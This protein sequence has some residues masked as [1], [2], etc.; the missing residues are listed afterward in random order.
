MS[1]MSYCR[2]HNTLHDLGDCQDALDE[3]GLSDLS[4]E[5]KECAILLIEKCQEIADEFRQL[6]EEESEQ[7]KMFDEDEAR[8]VN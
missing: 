1:N 5:E 8:P 7:D 6:M 2:F 4:D 3:T